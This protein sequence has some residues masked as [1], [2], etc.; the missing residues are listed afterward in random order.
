M[1]L[2]SLKA[3]G[4][5]AGRS[6]INQTTL[7]S[8]V[9]IDAIENYLLNG[10][11]E[12]VNY[13]KKNPDKFG[14]TIIK[15]LINKK[16]L[17][18]RL[19]KHEEIFILNQ[20][21]DLLKVFRYIKF[22]YKFYLCGKEKLNLG[23]PPYVLIEPVSTCNLRC[24]FCFQTD[25]SFTKKP[26]MGIMKFE[27]FKKIIDEADELGV[28]AITIASRGEPTLHK[29]LGEMFEYIGDKKNIFDVKTNTNATFLT[30]KLC[31]K[32]LSNNLTQIVI[33]A[34][35]YIKQDYERLRL[36]A[37]FEKILKNVDM[38]YNIR[39]KYYPEAMTEIRVSGVDSDKNL[40][41]DKFH[42]FW[43]QRSDHVTAGFPLER[44]NTYKN[45][46]HQKINDACENLWDRMY[47][48]FDG[49][50]NPCDQDYKSYLSYGDFN[51]QSIK[52]IWKSK[53]ISNIRNSHLNNKRNCINPC[54]RC[55]VTFS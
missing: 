40:D 52:E 32:M 12:I 45:N 7:N 15:N 4:S 33:S 27:L 11:D 20:K 22:R 10:L 47:I 42:E 9:D 41:R 13:N 37:N 53:I 19:N 46:P 3:I 51:D 55:G 14:D 2:E 34:D 23:Y 35:H 36:G 43:I 25:T 54:D 24:P 6:K 16:K 1:S 38:L 31:H 49:K 39:E 28:G 18:H 30:E 29:Q 17:I 44:W 8:E 50:A 48:W 26:F 21:Q 5:K